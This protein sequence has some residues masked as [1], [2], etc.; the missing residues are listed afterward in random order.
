MEIDS[1]SVLRAFARDL[2]AEDLLECLLINPA[3]IGD[4]LVGRSRAIEI[5]KSL[6]RSRSSTSTVIEAARPVGDRRIVCF[7]CDL[8]VS[9]AFADDE[10]AN[11]RP[12]LN[13]RIIAS[14]DSGRPVVLSETE[15]RATNTR[16]GLDVVVLY[17]SW[18]Q[19]QL[20]PDAVS[21][22]CASMAARFLENRNGFRI[23]RLISEI[24]GAEEVAFCEASHVWRVVRRF[25]ELSQQTRALCAITR[26]DALGARGSFINPL[27]H[28]KEPVFR[29]RDADQ[30]LLLAALSG[31]TDEELSSK[32]GLSLTGVK[33]RWISIFERTID[34]RPDLFP[35]LD[36][37]DLDGN[38]GQKR[39]R[40]KRHHVLAYV[41]THPE[42]LRP[43]E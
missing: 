4:E 38:D 40:Q 16:G 39:G 28:P 37:L 33:K 6:V 32:L 36:G 30:Q 15:L 11:P 19:G 8:A 22:V 41:R 27:F 1:P 5:W 21:E 23:N 12:G 13:S 42:E 3:R 14:I 7:G 20:H 31:L 17:G 35:R 43:F 18:P 34:V 24:A 25:D 2:R 10:L 26:E 29:F 9:R